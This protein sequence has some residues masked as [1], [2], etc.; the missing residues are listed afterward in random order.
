MAGLLATFRRTNPA[1]TAAFR[2]ASSMR[3]PEVQML[4]LL[5]RGFTYR[6][7]GIEFG[8]YTESVRR[9]LRNI[10]QQRH[11]QCGPEAVARAI[12]EKIIKA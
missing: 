8:I 12:G 10:Y 1:A 6:M 11:V 4:E 5:A 2:P 3:I 7:I 9:H